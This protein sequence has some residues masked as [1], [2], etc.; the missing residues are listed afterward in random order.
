[1]HFYKNNH[2]N[3]NGKI[4][5]ELHTDNNYVLPT[6]VTLTSLIAN[7]D[8]S[9]IYEIRVLG[10]NLTKKNIKLLKKAVGKYGCVIPHI[11]S[12]SK[13]EGT[14]PHVSS[15]DLFKFDLPD[16]LSDWDKV[17]YI[18]TDMIIQSDLS[19]LFNID[20]GDNY[21]AAVKDMAGMHEGH[22]EKLGH[23]NYFNA[24][25]MLM[26]LKKM[27]EENIG[28]KLIDYK[29]HKDC[30]HFM[31]QDALNF[32]FNEKVLYIS[33]I[34]NWMA[35]NQLKFSNQEIK[36]FYGID[37]DL[38]LDNAVIVH[39]TNRK[40]V[41]NYKNTWGFDLWFSYYKKSVLKHRYLNLLDAEIPRNN[42]F[43]WVP[44][45]GFN[46]FYIFNIPVVRVKETD[47]HKKIDLFNI[48]ILKIT[49]V[50]K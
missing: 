11:S 15:T 36:D 2:I 33:P 32:V 12:F 38:S 39:L 22:A 13:F 47:I 9:S 5:I 48:R 50:K 49:K 16:V 18:D 4:C 29:L 26:N 35:P 21:I 10:N 7:K 14:H 46:K 28:A 44:R 45:N 30:G 1:M 3:T 20:L 6:I 31:S 25:M 41:W 8:K 34:Y 27:R 23:K 42:K 24:G 17:L 37:F 40:K 43:G 19:E